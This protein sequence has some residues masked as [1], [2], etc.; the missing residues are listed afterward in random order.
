M[1]KVLDF[2]KYK[3][4]K[5]LGKIRS[6]AYFTLDE[7]EEIAWEFLES[8]LD[9]DELQEIAWRIEQKIESENDN[10]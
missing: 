4:E 7:V 10:G 9:K 6:E 2:K 5:E 3:K 1:T 8:V